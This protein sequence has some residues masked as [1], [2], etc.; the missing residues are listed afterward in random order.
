MKNKETIIGWVLIAVLFVGFFFYQSKHVEEER[1]KKREE[2]ATQQLDSLNKAKT[3]TAS[4]VSKT[5]TGTIAA[6]GT[7]TASDTN[8]TIIADKL[9]ADTAAAQSKFG[10]FGNDATGEEQTYTIENDLL[11]IAISNKGGQ[12]KS[13]ELKDY[14]TWDK[15][16]LVLLN[17]KNNSL[18][19]QFIIDGERTIDTKDFYFEPVGEPFKVTGSNTKSIAFRLKAGDGRYFEQ[20]YTLKGDSYMFDY[21]INMVGLDSIIPANNNYLSI[22]WNAK[23]NS[24]EKDLTTERTHS[25]LYY[26][27]A[28][29]NVD[30]LSDTKNEDENRFDTPLE[31]ISYK[32]Q[33]FNT[34][35]FSKGEIHSGKLKTFYG[36]DDNSYVKSYTANFTVPY[37]SADSVSYAFQYYM[38]PNRYNTL[39][40]YGNDFED[41]IKLG[42]D[43]W[44]FSWIKYITRVIIIIFNLFDKLHLNY[45]IIILLMTLILKLAL[46]PLT[47]KSIE[48]SAKMK[49]LAPEL[50]ALKEK[51]GDDQTKISQEQ[52]KLYQRAGV[53]PLGGC[54]P[55]LLQM[56]ILIAMYNFFPASIELRQQ[57]FLWAND[58]STYDSIYTFSKPLFGSIDHISL[59]TILM[60]ITSVLQAVMNNQMNAMGAQ[61]PGM[62]YMPYIM[63]VM[64]M[65]L[66]NKFPAALTYYYLLQ[67]LLG[68]AHQWIIQK[69]FIDDAKLRKQIEENK[70]NPKAASGWQKKLQDMQKQNEQRVKPKK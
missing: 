15:K 66:F 64:L 40:S 51:Y 16:P 8:R 9:T 22:A 29:D 58:L 25:A 18:S 31:W 62:K 12:I 35:L 45:G 17:D 48:S 36:K 43:F 3:V 57:A 61:Q 32:Q 14:K 1:K 60:T 46:H 34:T 27:Y 6:V 26:K 54:L 44:M 38:G 56:P 21:N 30:H 52:M 7:G 49:I 20:K 63:P 55:L 4:T 37:K 42:P 50:A 41:I 11:K 23:I 70:K 47:S 19:Y 68:V 28:K 53:S 2:Q 65:F 33:F 69:F 13:V 24:V 10:V 39:K 59:F 67:N 5:D